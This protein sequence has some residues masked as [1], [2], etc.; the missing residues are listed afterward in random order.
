MPSGPAAPTALRTIV[1]IGTV[2]GLFSALFGVGGGIVIVPMLV[3]F[4]GL[5]TRHATATSLA[6]LVLVAAWGA[7]GHGLYGNVRVGPALALGGPAV[8]GVLAGT[9]LQSRLRA[10]TLDRA[11]AALLVV[12]AVFLVFR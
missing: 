2:G 4:A 8:V 5:S 7:I 10:A 3:A 6:A 9:W 1:L 11:M 12:I